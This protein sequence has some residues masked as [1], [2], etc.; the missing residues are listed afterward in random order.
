MYPPR[1]AE[2]HWVTMSQIAALMVKALTAAPA[3]DHA[4]KDSRPTP[5]PTAIKIN[6]AD[7]ATNAPAAIAG[8]E[9]AG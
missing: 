4:E 5:E 7:T 2:I 6:E 9:A 8:H 3:L 1:A